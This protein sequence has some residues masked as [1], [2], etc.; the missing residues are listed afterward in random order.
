MK[1]IEMGWRGVSWSLTKDGGLG[2]GGGDDGGQLL[3]LH[4]RAS[5]QKG[6]RPG[7]KEQQEGEPKEI[8]A[9]AE[10]NEGSDD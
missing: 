10:E 3:A 8:W 6:L 7:A 9:E 5:L 1:H 4:T 2:P